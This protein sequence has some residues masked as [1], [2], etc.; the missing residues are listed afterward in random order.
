MKR[1]TILLPAKLKALAECHA[2][3]R[4]VS[5]GSLIRSALERELARPAD[6]ATADDALLSDD[7]TFA[8]DWPSDV[9]SN[10]DR[11][12]YGDGSSRPECRGRDR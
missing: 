3:D 1:T 4:G 2:R 5:L 7:V 9:S 8:D 12:V 6:R 11:Y 10:L